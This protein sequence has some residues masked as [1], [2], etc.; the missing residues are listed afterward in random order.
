MLLLS[1]FLDDNSHKCYPFAEPNELPTDFIVDAKFMVT[2]NINKNELYISSISISDNNLV[3]NAST[4]VSD[5]IVELGEL[6][7]VEVPTV[8]NTE[9]SCKLVNSVHNVIIEGL[10]TIGTIE[11]LTKDKQIYTLDEKGK[12]FSGCVIPVTEW[13][14]G[15][16]IND[17]IYTGIVELVADKGIEFNIINDDNNDTTYIT[18]CASGFERPEGLSIDLLTDEEL[19]RKM[20]KYWDNPIKSINGVYPNSEGNID[21]SVDSGSK[22]YLDISKVE[23]GIV[24][25]DI[26]SA[27]CSFDEETVTTLYDN[28]QRLNE[29]AGALDK[30][31]ESLENQVNALSSEL[32]DIEPMNRM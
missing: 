7:H 31:Q 26:Y 32:V 20:E 24:L 6:L 27:V 2:G 30:M 8:R 5:H 12:I 17:Q 3:I 16:R 11:S 23:G 15:I 13:C 22:E 4:L 21:I 18:I 28:I 25:K 10:I 14:T 9:F 29:R 1:E 19:I